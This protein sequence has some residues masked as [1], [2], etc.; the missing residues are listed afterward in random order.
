MNMKQEYNNF[1]DLSSI[2]TDESSFN[3]L[4][5][6]IGDFGLELTGIDKPETTCP[7]AA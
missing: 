3:S 2:F 7:A 1:E 6:F 5:Q 4:V